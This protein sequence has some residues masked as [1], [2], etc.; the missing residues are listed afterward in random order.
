MVESFSSTL[1]RFNYFILQQNNLFFHVH[2][3]V[4][5]LSFDFCFVFFFSCN[6][7]GICIAHMFFNRMKNIDVVAICS[8]FDTLLHLTSMI[9]YKILSMTF[10][11]IIVLL[12][13]QMCMK[14]FYD[15]SVI[16]I[17]SMD[18]ETCRTNMWRNIFY[19]DQ[20]Y[21]LEERVSLAITFSFPL[22]YI[23][24]MK[25]IFGFFFL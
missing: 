3:R 15:F 11:Y 25:I 19:I 18:H 23:Q 17:P 14:Y 6:F 24:K 10:P 16:D 4:L 9:A 8:C 21:P 1:L 5:F 7:S 13:L 12:L 20:F 22:K 2:M